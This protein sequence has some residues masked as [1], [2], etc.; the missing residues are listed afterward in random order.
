[1]ALRRSDQNYGLSY[2]LKMMLVKKLFQV[3]Q[4]VET[5][6]QAKFLKT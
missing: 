4:R 1:V 5:A 3:K 2:Y 6:P